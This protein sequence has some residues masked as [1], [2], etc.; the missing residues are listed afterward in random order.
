MPC[1]RDYSTSG[2]WDL[3]NAPE[4]ELKHGECR[5]CRTETTNYDCH[6]GVQKV[7]KQVIT[8]H[9]ITYYNIPTYRD[10]RTCCV[11]LHQH[12]QILAVFFGT[13]AQPW[14]PSF[15]LEPCLYKFFENLNISSTKKIKLS[16]QTGQTEE[17]MNGQVESYQLKNTSVPA[18]LTS[19][20][21][22]FRILRTNPS[23]KF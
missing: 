7:S 10:I 17:L 8:Y 5:M 1:H 13:V 23:K 14:L 3:L 18:L 16:N 19:I 15:G 12:C 4:K 9:S 22:P 2:Q 21:K 20:G 6:F 11:P